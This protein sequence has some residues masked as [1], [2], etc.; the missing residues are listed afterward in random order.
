MNR[1]K[2]IIKILLAVNAVLLCCVFLLL[3]GIIRD[4]PNGMT[5]A[6][7]DALGRDVELVNRENGIYTY[8]TAVS[9]PTGGSV[10]FQ[11]IDDEGLRTNY[12]QQMFR[13]IGEAYFQA[14]EIYWE[15]AEV[16]GLPAWKLTVVYPAQA[17]QSIQDFCEYIGEFADL[18][19]KSDAFTRNGHMVNAFPAI[20][21]QLEESG[22]VWEFSYNCYSY[23]G[24][25]REAFEEELYDFVSR[26]AAETDPEVLASR[27]EK[28]HLEWLEK[29]R[30]YIEEHL[31]DYLSREADMVFELEDGREYRMIVTDYIMGDCFY[32]LL[33]V[34]A[35]GTDVF[36][37]NPDPFNQDMGY[38]QWMIFV[39]EELGFA[40]LSGDALESGDLYRTVDGGESFENIEWPQVEGTMEDGTVIYPF[41]FAEE[42]YE[43]DGKLY[44]IVNQ[45]ITKS[46]QNQAGISPKALF[47]SEDR[48]ESWSFVEEI[49]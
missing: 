25:T 4:I 2:K 20:R 24:Y 47:V 14:D 10:S 48:G 27:I 23:P 34:E 49:A 39:D 5:E 6:V 32:I 17:G 7:R 26:K 40:C 36:L 12:T 3:T 31:D 15:G 21:I 16:W 13:Y 45:G 38:V 30:R 28:E 46:Y 22:S 41:D 35:D 43:K 44:L 1:K 37:L 11:A 42:L 18:C 29:S 19:M 8:K 33:G 9:V